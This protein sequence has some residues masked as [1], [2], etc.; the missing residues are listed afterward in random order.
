MWMSSETAA[1]RFP[2]HP[3]CGRYTH[4]SCHVGDRLTLASPKAD[5][6][7]HD[8][9]DRNILGIR[10][11]LAVEV[12]RD[13]LTKKDGPMLRHGRRQ[14]DRPSAELVEVRYERFRQAR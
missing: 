2:G 9:F 7:P 5:V 4:G 1:P 10:L 6:I 14:E 3:S 11:D 12:R 13:I 8:A